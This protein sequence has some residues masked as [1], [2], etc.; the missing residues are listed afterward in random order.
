MDFGGKDI[1]DEEGGNERVFM[2]KEDVKGV[3]GAL[4]GALS[5]FVWSLAMLS[6]III[7]VCGPMEWNVLISVLS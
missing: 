4:C 1:M 6:I 2:K 5:Y 3:G 7:C